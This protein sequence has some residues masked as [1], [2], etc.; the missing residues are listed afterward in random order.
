M[1]DGLLVSIS[2]VAVLT[3]LYST[4]TRVPPVIYQTILL[5]LVIYKTWKMC[6]DEEIEEGFAHLVFRIIVQDHIRYFLA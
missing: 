5:F 1:G 4:F 6:S 2:F 3:L